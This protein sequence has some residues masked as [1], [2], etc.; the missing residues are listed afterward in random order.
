MRRFQARQQA[1]VSLA[2][3]SRDLTFCCLGV[4]R[5]P[6]GR[7]H[8]N[9][10][11]HFR[12]MQEEYGPN[13]LDNAKVADIATG[14]LSLAVGCRELAFAV[15]ESRMN[16][17]DEYFLSLSLVAGRLRPKSAWQCVGFR[18]SNRQLVAG[19][20]KSPT[21]IYFLSLALGAGRV[22]SQSA[23]RCESLRHSYR[24]LVAGRWK[25]RTCICGPGVLQ[26]P[27]GRLHSFTF[28]CCRKSTAQISLAM[29][30]FFSIATGRCLLFVHL[31]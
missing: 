7:I 10:F 17:V 25:S 4:V 27:S 3:G 2:F 24:P 8:S 31:R 19:R 28:A 21:Y 20:W 13:Q 6:C 9:T 1:I 12:L 11:F 5:E 26:E 29:G 23:W 15:R 22:R 14:K 18:H 16:R 30:R